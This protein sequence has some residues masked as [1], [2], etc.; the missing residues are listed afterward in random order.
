MP[1]SA[2]SSVVEQR[3]VEQE[4]RLGRYGAISGWAALRWRGASYFDGQSRSD[5]R[6]LPVPLAVGKECLR[7]DP[8]FVRLRRQLPLWE[9][10]VHRGLRCAV[11]ERALFDEIIRLRGARAG[12][13]AID[14]AVAAGL[15]TVGEFWLYLAHVGPRNGVVLAREAAGLA[16]GTHWS[17]Q[18]AWMCQCWCLDAGLPT[19]LYNVPVFDRHGNLLGIPDLLDADAGVVGEY[20]GAVHR[21]A[22]QH[23]RDVERA[24]RFRAHGLEY[25]EV[26]AGRM[27]DAAT[28]TRMREVRARA[29]FLPSAERDWTLEVPAWWQERHPDARAS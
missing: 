13:V 5:G 8:G 22:A 4:A 14:M 11:W 28:V 1:A 2:D 15:G 23:R 21:D 17:P 25:F 26:V 20:Q 18:E 29:K 7:A 19:P 12:A 3:I 10:S 27:Y 6:L 24:E 9:W 16:C